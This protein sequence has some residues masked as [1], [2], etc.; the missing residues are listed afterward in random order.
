MIDDFDISGLDMADFPFTD[1][2]FFTYEVDNTLPLDQRVPTEKEVLRTNFDA[3]R[4]AK[5]HNGGMNGANY[6]VY[7][8]MTPNPNSTSMADKYLPVPVKRGMRF[9]GVAYGVSVVGEVEIVRPSQ[10]GGCSA[11]IKVVTES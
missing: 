5:L 1:G 4:S 7:W 9:R 10:L 8:P 6:T 11:D 2:V 3:Q